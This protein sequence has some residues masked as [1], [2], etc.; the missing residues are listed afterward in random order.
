[1]QGTRALVN[2]TRKPAQDSSIARSL[3]APLTLVSDDHTRR[4]C[5]CVRLLLERVR[6]LVLVRACAHARAHVMCMCELVESC[7]RARAD[8]CGDFGSIMLM[9]TYHGIVFFHNIFL[10]LSA[11]ARLS[12]HSDR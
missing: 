9:L 12:S 11:S 2:H 10:L 4:R 3:L 1:M 7:V 6:V 5:A 8:L